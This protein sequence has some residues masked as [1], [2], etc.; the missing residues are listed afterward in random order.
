MTTVPAAMVTVAFFVGRPVAGLALV[1]LRLVT[2]PLLP[3]A[4]AVLRRLGGHLLHGLRRE[5]H[6]LVHRPGAWPALGVIALWSSGRIAVRGVI[7]HVT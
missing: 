3:L 4:G 1:G 5:F 6:R 7:S 2:L